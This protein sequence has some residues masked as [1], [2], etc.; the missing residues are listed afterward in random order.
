MSSS[1]IDIYGTIG[2][3]RIIRYLAYL[4]SIICLTDFEYLGFPLSWSALCL[5]SHIF[6]ALVISMIVCNLQN[7]STIIIRKS[8]VFMLFVLLSDIYSF[9]SVILYL[10]L[11]WSRGSILASNYVL[12]YLTASVSL[13][14]QF[15][16]FDFCF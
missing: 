10:L 8:K 12:N 3:I 9:Q 4:A 2:Y 13:T 11:I 5:T 14:S 15:L 16:G 7:K 1:N 6:H